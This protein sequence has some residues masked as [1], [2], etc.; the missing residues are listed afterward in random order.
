MSSF[1][2]FCFE[3]ICQ[4]TLLQHSVKNHVLNHKLSNTIVDKPF[5]CYKK[6]VSV[7]FRHQLRIIEQQKNISQYYIQKTD[8]KCFKYVLHCS[9]PIFL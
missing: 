5:Y 9:Y 2:K 7:L 8:F 4:S 3:N 1:L 6:P